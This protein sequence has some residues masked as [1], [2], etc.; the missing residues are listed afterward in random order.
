MQIASL[1]CV[2]AAASDQCK[3]CWTEGHAGSLPEVQ[4]HNP[5]AH[6]ALKT[7]HRVFESLASD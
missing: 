3:F 2:W 7:V 4:G 5:V 1:G 6:I